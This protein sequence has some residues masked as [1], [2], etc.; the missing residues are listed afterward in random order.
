[1]ITYLNIKKIVNL[2]FSICKF[3]I[4]PLIIISSCDCELTWKYSIT[5]NSG[6]SL[7]VIYTALRYSKQ[8]TIY[9]NNNETK[10]LIIADIIGGCKIYDHEKNETLNEFKEIQILKNDSILIIRNPLLKREWEYKKI[11]KHD[12]E[13]ILTINTNDFN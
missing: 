12:G 7:K 4:F 9:F 2:L 11:S 10:T 13:Y 8:D 6:Y 1:M 3:L 5:N